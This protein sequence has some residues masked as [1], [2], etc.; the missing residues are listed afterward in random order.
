MAAISGLPASWGVAYGQ[1]APM[2]PPPPAR[3]APTPVPP[4]IQ[5]PPGVAVPGGPTSG[6]PAVSPLPVATVPPA[7]SGS[8]AGGDL[9]APGSDGGFLAGVPAASAGSA[10]LSTPL[11]APVRAT[12]FVPAQPDRSMVVRLD[13]LT[14]QA[15]R[16]PIPDGVVIARVFQLAVVDARTG[17]LVREHARPITLL[18]KYT[19]ADLALA[20]GDPSRLALLRQDE[21]AGQLFQVPTEVDPATRVL[22]AFLGHTSLFALAVLPAREPGSTAQAPTAPILADPRASPP[23]R[24]VA[25]IV[26]PTGLPNTGLGAP[27]PAAEADLSSRYLALLQALGRLLWWP[28]VPGG[29]VLIL[30]FVG[31]QRARPK[32]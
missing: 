29:L 5:A 19:E 14:V 6:V 17:Q 26:M 7:L 13:P 32:T 2:L 4:S 15:L 25:T 18:F 28:L 23:P 27:V 9:T 1:T 30:G 31:W 21:S 22:T 8:P 3:G 12:V 11:D 10:V 16:V 24:P 20:G